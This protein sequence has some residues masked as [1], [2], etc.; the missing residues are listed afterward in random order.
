[1]KQVLIFTAMLVLVGCIKTREQLRAEH[2][3]TTLP[4]QTAQQ[5]VEQ[6][7]EVKEKAPPTGYRFEEIDEQL[8]QLNGRVE[9]LENQIARTGATST[10]AQEAELKLKQTQD[11]KLVAYEEA[12]KKLESDVLTL[13]KEIEQLK[14]PPANVAAKKGGASATSRTAYEEG[15]E[16]FTAK[17][18]RE[19]I[20]SYQKYRDSNPK[21][22]NYADATYKMGVAFH[23][24]GMK[25]EA[26]VFLEEVKE[27]FPNSKEAKKALTRMKTLK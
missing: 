17:K 10:E 16:L 12:L 14:A 25:D 24:L 7:R 19:A 15:E 21:G 1:M 6:A 8:R 22:R 5:Q 20:V 2:T 3:D 9:N 11:L 23:E 4:K 18:W 27:K 13:S 26:R